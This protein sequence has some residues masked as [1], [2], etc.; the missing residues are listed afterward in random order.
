MIE[1]KLSEIDRNMKETALQAID[2]IEEKS[3]AENFMLSETIDS[4]Y[5]YGICFYQ[6]AFLY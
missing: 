1:L 6:K 5:C 4:V 2:Q 3:Y